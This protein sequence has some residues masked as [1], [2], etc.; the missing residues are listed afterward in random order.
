[1]AAIG[2]DLE[3]DVPFDLEFEIDGDLHQPRA[4]VVWMWRLADGRNRFGFEFNRLR[5]L[6]CSGSTRSCVT[7]RSSS[8]VVAGSFQCPPSSLVVRP[9]CQRPTQ[10]LHRLVR[11][12]QRT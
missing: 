11:P 5:R 10:V 1:M 6:A 7:N 12:S 2:F 9:Q 3:E 8:V 4:R